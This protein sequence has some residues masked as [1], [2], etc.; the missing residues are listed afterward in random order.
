MG[1][2]H[3]TSG[4]R[5]LLTLPGLANVPLWT[6]INLT[7]ASI[8]R[9]TCTVHCADH[10]PEILR[11]GIYTDEHVLAV[12]VVAVTGDGSVSFVASTSQVKHLVRIRDAPDPVSTG[13]WD[14]HD[15]MRCEW[16]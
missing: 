12:M 11:Q 5:A 10:E 16:K 3:S 7:S 1:Q 6:L 4:K 9:T 14:R 8:A 15:E 2:V 13:D